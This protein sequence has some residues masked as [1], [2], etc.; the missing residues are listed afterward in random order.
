MNLMMYRQQIANGMS[1]DWLE[2]DLVDD[3]TMF[4]CLN[5]AN[6]AAKRAKDVAGLSNERF[7]SEYYSSQLWVR[8]ASEYIL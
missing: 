8:K 1:Y 5:I 2:N 4:D 6:C 3:L 7:L